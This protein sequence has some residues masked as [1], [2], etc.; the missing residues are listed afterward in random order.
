MTHS[1]LRCFAVFCVILPLGACSTAQLVETVTVLN[2]RNC[3]NTVAGI[4]ERTLA[5]LRRVRQS[6]LLAPPDD[7][8]IE[9]ADDLPAL[10]QTRIFVFSK[11]EQPTPG[12]A[13]ELE[14]STLEGETLTVAFT[15]VTPASDAV[16]AQVLTH[17]CIAVGIPETKAKRLIA[18]DQ[19]G[20]F[21]RLEL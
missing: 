20:E 4:T 5:E 1:A 8:P 6:R 15:W 17:P 13:F 3:S 16:L 11:G 18:V 10:E 12:Y 19:S 21:A 2:E 14:R 7:A 9:P